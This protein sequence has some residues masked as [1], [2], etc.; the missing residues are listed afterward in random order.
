V[1][2]ADVRPPR[3]L[4]LAYALSGAC[5]LV[6]QVV[7][8]HLFTEELGASGTTFLVVLCAFIG[9]LGLGAV[10]SDR[11]Y[12]VVE[13]RVG[14][15]GLRNYGRTEL[16]VGLVSAALALLTRLPLARLLGPFPYRLRVVEGVALYLPTLSYDALKLGLAVLAVGIPCFLMG[17][18]F[19]YLCSLFPSDARL[20]SRLYAANTLGACAAVLATEFW[21][22]GV[23]GYIGCLGVATVGTIGLGLWF[24]LVNPAQGAPRA[25]G[26]ATDRTAAPPLSVY[27]AVLSGFLCG[28]AQS[29]AFVLLKLVLGPTRGAFALLAFFSILGIWIASTVV[30]RSPPTRGALLFAGWL[31]LAASIAVWLRQPQLSES[32]VR[33]GIEGSPFESPDA[34]AV[35][36]SVLA[37]GLMLFVP[38]AL[39]STLLPALCDRQQARGENL[40]FTY[41]ANTLS[42]LA[43]VLVFGWALQ[44]VNFFY[45][46]RVFAVAAAAGLLLLTAAPKDGRPARGR[47]YVA[48]AAA[49][50]LAMA[51]LPR[52]PDMAKIGGRQGAGALPGVYRST[53]QH[54]FWVREN[55]PTKSRSLMFDGHSMSAS[56]ADG[57]IYMRVMAHLPLLL[58]REPQ[59]VLLICFGVG[60]TAD[61]I[62]T[63]ADVVRLD[64]VDLNRDVFL[65]DRWFAAANRDVLTDPRLRLFCDDG[66]QYLKLT[67]A[68]YDFVTME[69]PPPLQPGISRLYSLE[70][71]DA[72]RRRL[73]PG[74][75]VSQWLPE[76][77]MGPEGV[78]LIVATF[79]R[80]FRHALLF[81]GFGRDLI[82]VGSDVSFD[83][84]GAAA[85]LGREGA[86]RTALAQLG[87]D[88]A[89]RLFATIL[90]T[91]SS[92]RRTWGAGPAIRDGFRSL[93][94]L[95]VNAAV[96][97]QHPR[98]TW[99]R[100]KESL[101]LDEADV[102]ETLRASAPGAVV[103]VERLW[104]DP[105][106]LSATMPPWYFPPSGPR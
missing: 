39:W 40:S 98:S 74:G 27:P 76:A 103:E 34:A 13:A 16:L 48:A 68:T 14:G 7:W 58:H 50:G 9:G 69:P 80:S 99:T 104:S 11:V 66:R 37:T 55:R 22:L 41:G 52:S 90:R 43:G 67:D 45:A 86:V 100:P 2:G 105:R 88:G 26:G 72:I 17:L 95:Q 6:Y 71:Y 106:Q 42:F 59:S 65:L 82:L 29:L 61:A 92:L 38:Y 73:A 93:E 49:L 89:P 1:G 15:R 44:Y 75:L 21:G 47:G 78:D 102:L 91:D 57:Q 77:Q 70:F 10:A 28:G 8:T 87:F 84:G 32:L 83:F 51:A 23:I 30:H 81:S 54:F 25:A 96:Q 5:A 35:A 97:R 85:R 46:A 19:P 33:W 31:G 53:P 36:V 20:P 62:R 24:T 60:I 64:A 3:G 94:A 79:V 12:R 18:T 4:G 63:H 56:D 101:V